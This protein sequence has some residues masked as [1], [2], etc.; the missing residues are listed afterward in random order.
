MSIRR[1]LGLVA[2]G[3]L[4]PAMVACGG[5][6]SASGSGD[7]TV[8]FAGS[9][10]DIQKAIESDIF[11]KFTEETG[12]KVVYQPGTAG[13][14]LA[15][16]QSS[17]NN[18]DID[19]YFGNAT[20]HAQGTAAGLWDKID[21]AA[22]PS[23]AK[24]FEDVRTTDGFGVV[25]GQYMTGLEY[26]TKIFEEKGFDPPTSW[27]DLWDPKYQGHVALYDI[28][29]GYT[30]DVLPEWAKAWGIDPTDT[31]ALFDKISELKSQQVGIATTPP[32]LAT[33]LQQE[34]AW[35][36]YNSNLQV[37]Q[38]A[39]TGVPVKFVAP[40]SGAVRFENTLDVVK[41]APHSENAQKLIEFMLNEGSQ[42]TIAEKLTMS[43]VIPGLTLPA[44]VAEATGYS[45]DGPSADVVPAQT[46]LEVKQ[47]S[48]WSTAWSEAFGQ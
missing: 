38:N 24:S 34:A 33:L 44:E 5:S 42:T 17:K 41:D 23:A 28:A 43:P 20:T 29:I 31:D 22:V 4:A 8:V 10:A 32:A 40:S 45:P 16:I 30:Q 11:T 21:P 18:P 3:A 1:I 7:E 46:E 2:L 12:I 37:V 9:G 14:N 39:A 25:F 6:D 35:I 47:L 36:T 26:N 15:K 19:V 27:K 13:E 48:E